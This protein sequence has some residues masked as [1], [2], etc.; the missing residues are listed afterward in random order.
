MPELDVKVIT[1]NNE[2]TLQHNKWMETIETV[3]VFWFT[4]EYLFRKNKIFYLFS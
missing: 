1:L 2:K 4:L 3:C